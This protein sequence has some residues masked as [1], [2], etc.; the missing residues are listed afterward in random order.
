LVAAFV[1]VGVLCSAASAKLVNYVIHVSV[2]GCR[3]DAITNLGP[4]YVPNFYRMRTEGAFTDNARTDYDYTETLPNHTTQLTGRG[5]LG[6][7]GH[8]WTENTD[9]DPGVTLHTNKGSYVAG[10]FDV[11][12]DYGLWTGEYA[13]KSKFSLFDTSWNATNGA[14]DGTPPD[15]GRDK[16]DVYVNLVDTLPLTYELV[17]EMEDQPLHY[18]FIHWGDPDRIGHAHGFDPTPGSA[19]SNTIIEMDVRLGVIFDMVDNDPLLN[20]RT[21][22]ILTSDHGGVGTNHANAGL[23]ENYTIP[24]Y[25][26]GPGVTAGASLYALNPTTRQ[27]PGTGRPT[28]SASPQ[29]IRNGEVTN[30]ALKVLGLPAIPGSTIGQAQDLALNTTPGPAPSAPTATA[31][32]GATN[33]SFNAN[34]NS[35]SGATGYL[36]DVATDSSFTNYVSGYCDIVVGDVLSYNVTGLSASTTFYYRVWAYNLNGTS[37]GSNTITVATSAN[38][39]PP[40]NPVAVDAT[41]V[42]NVGFTANWDVACGATGYLLDVSTSATFGSY[43]SGYQNLDV[44][45]VI[46][47]AVGPV[48][49]NT[50]YYYRVWAYNQ[51]GSSGVSN[52]ASVTT[53]DV[54]WCIPGELLSH[55]DMEYADSYSVCPGWTPYSAGPGAPSWAKEA[56]IRHGGLASQRAK[57]I[58]G[59]AGSLIGV[60]QT[61]DANVGD[62]FTFEGWVYPET[63]PAYA[64]AA[65]AARWDGSI[66]IPDGTASWK[67]SGGARLTWTKIQA[68]SGNA[69]SDRVTLFLD[70]R[71][72][73]GS[74]AITAYWDDV[75]SY[76]AYVPPP[77]T[78]SVAGST[79]LDV[80]VNAGCNSTNT[81]AEY[82][83]T[84]GGGAY[85]LGTHWVQADGTVGTTAAWQTESAWGTTT[86]AGLTTDITYTFKTKA[87]YSGTITQETSLGL[88]AEGT[89]SGGTSSPT[90]TQHPS[91]QNV[92]SGATA[93]FTVAATG[94]G[95]LTYQWQRNQSNLNNGGHYAGCTTATL[96]VSSADGNDVA[97][98]RCV[99]TDSVGSA[100]SNEAALSLKAATTITQDPT[101]QSVSEGGTATFSVNATG[102]GTLTY[103]WQKN[104]ANLSNGGHYSGCTTATLTVSSADANDEAYYRCVVTG[105]C[106]SANSNEASLTVDG[107]SCSTPTL[108]N[109]SFE[110]GNTNGVAASWTGYRRPTNPTTVWTIQTANPPSGGGAQYQQIAN[111]SATG[112]G[113]VRQDITG[114]TVGATYQIS[115]WMRTNSVSATCTVKCSPTASTN[116]STAQNLNPAQSTTSSSWVP[117][118]GVITATGTAMTL[119]LDG[120]T[121]G[122]GLNKA[123]CF[124]A[125]S[126]ECMIATIQNGDFEGGNTNGVGS[127]WTGYQRATNPTTVWTIQTA[128]PP[129]GG[130]LQYQQIANTSASG[131][132]G[133]RQ[134]V[135]NCA[136]G[137]TYTIAGWMRTN[138][139][140]ATCTVKCSP[141]ASTDWSTAVDL[142]PV[143][144]T[145]SS[146]WV[147]FSGTV[148]ATGTSMTIWLDGHT[149]GTGLNKA[150]CFD[151]VTVSD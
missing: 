4:T 44:G 104:Q 45:N 133:V 110:G 22:I 115:G 60:Y 149:G 30:V 20:G 118:S 141:T 17:A 98:Y 47:W 125:I 37:G 71:Q 50:T 19:Y 131:G 85:A 18:A 54:N 6:P 103:Q 59:Q 144:T 137:V 77:P 28:Y 9:P 86:V 43:V 63:N 145:T 7:T 25:V 116:W 31:A 95:T 38:V 46:G 15:D 35:V 114:C 66:T 93:T 40:S 111:T 112:G 127:G 126:V 139:A 10:V 113:G 105:G 62:A 16:I 107:G 8:N 128:S 55:G 1:V 106:G 148:T 102:D 97:N 23:V 2:D 82:A 87:R 64:Q 48:S 68:F 36:L 3:P 140:S 83:V 130:G 120:H 76:R 53:E 108:L 75:V 70:S 65:M 90:I 72:K 94:E 101:N 58:N 51:L 49:S 69:T 84:I 142:N 119:W 12:H 146:S 34:W 78:V 52:T 89:P 92:C 73:S 132:G 109:A 74:V 117:F 143:Q 121:G 96:T 79:S 11:A 123:A 5:V 14:L 33:C 41:D 32:T 13:S 39:S 81:A 100:N 99:V 91:P 57:N 136:T 122:T 29:P 134:N 88:G 129:T 61:I 27:D 80:D 42:T 56:A 67:V 124:D 138:S 24:F 21:V 150:S 147:A 135:I 26:W 151:S